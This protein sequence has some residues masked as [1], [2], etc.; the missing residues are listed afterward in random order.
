M[1][2]S[3]VLNSLTICRKKALRAVFDDKKSVIEVDVS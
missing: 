3:E 1:A 2:R